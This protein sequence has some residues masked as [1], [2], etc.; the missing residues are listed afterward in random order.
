MKK[1]ILAA[2]V[3]FGFAGMSFAQSSTANA[4]VTVNTNVVSSI[5]CSNTHNL[6][7]GTVVQGA[8]A[9]VAPT[10][11]NAG[12]FT[13]TG[14]L[15][16]S[17]SYVF[18]APADL[19]SGANTLTF[20]PDIPVYNT[21]NSQTGTNPFGAVAGGIMSLGAGVT[22]VYIWVGGSVTPSATQ[23]VGSYSGSYTLT[24]TYQ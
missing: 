11:A 4:S 17:V 9:S 16:S 24:V 19:T 20:T 15:N 12:A 23:A 22:S 18:A 8:T 5:S 14:T 13:V 21:S 1:L 10:S 7:L 3:V 6:D 2:A